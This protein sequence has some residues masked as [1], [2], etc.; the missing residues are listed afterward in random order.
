MPFFVGSVSPNLSPCLNVNHK[1]PSPMPKFL[2]HILVLAT[3]QHLSPGCGSPGILT[4]LV[5]NVLLNGSPGFTSCP[6]NSIQMT[7]TLGSLFVNHFITT[8]TLGNCF[9][10][11]NAAINSASPNGMRLMSPATKLAPGISLP[12]RSQRASLQSRPVDLQPFCWNHA[13]QRPDPQPA[14]SMGCHFGSQRRNV[15]FEG[16]PIGN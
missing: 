2:H 8:S 5:A 3:I 10:S 11:S 12:A 6:S 1:A 7:H 16:Q 4:T 13:T 14:S 9:C 15:T